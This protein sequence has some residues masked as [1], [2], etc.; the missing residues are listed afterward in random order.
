[1]ISLTNGPAWAETE[2]KMMFWTILVA[3]IVM[4]LAITV[5]EWV[6]KRIARAVK[7]LV[8]V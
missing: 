6:F 2:P 7:F 3:C 8:G 1:M 4:G 5:V